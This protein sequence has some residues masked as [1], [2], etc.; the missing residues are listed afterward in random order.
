MKM[1]NVKGIEN[2]KMQ[3]NTPASWGKGIAGVF[4]WNEEGGRGD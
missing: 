1:V 2:V 3:K 4:N